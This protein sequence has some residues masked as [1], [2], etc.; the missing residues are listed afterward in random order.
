MTAVSICT[1]I[2]AI[3]VKLMAGQLLILM[4]TSNAVFLQLGGGTTMFTVNISH[5][6]P[7]VKYF[8]CHSVYRQLAISLKKVAVL[9]SACLV[10]YCYSKQ[11]RGCMLFID[12]VASVPDLIGTLQEVLHLIY[13]PQT[14]YIH[15]SCMH[16]YLVVSSKTIVKTLAVTD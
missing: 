10:A 4:S 3:H 13:A 6:K 15:K 1:F 12:D 14:T 11:T 9:I 7:A 5:T 2:V 16:A 8:M